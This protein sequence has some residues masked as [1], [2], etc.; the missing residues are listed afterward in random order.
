M[1]TN[2]ISF[3]G[4][5]NMASSIIG[6]LIANGYSAKQIT[7][8]NPSEGKLVKLQQQYGIHITTNN[9]AA[10]EQADIL[11]LAVKTTTAQSSLSSTTCN[12]TTT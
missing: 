11:V 3:I 5:G 7:A 1:R 10:A 6:G 8:A 9:I 4:A 2:N 12:F